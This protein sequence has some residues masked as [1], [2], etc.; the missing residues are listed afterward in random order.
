[1]EQSVFLGFGI[2][3]WITIT[4]LIAVMA[5]LLF[6]R[7]RA[8]LVFMGAIGV[9]FVTGVLDLSEA[10]SG[11]TNS[12]VIIIGIM[13]VVVTGLTHTGVLLWI[14]RHVLGQTKGC[15][16]AIIRL[17]MPVA[18]LSSFIINDS[19][20]ILFVR[21]VKMWSRK[22]GLQ[23]SKL[24]IPLSYAAEMGGALLILATPSGLVINGMF[25]KETGQG[26]GIQLANWD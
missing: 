5:T 3:A 17:M 13:F 11:F 6:T 1:M 23:P 15:A 18:V 16:I 7:L 14:V 21:I 9:L 4:T 8:D 25:E 2:D 10:F 24:L 26:L 19:I 12:S 22:L 20:V